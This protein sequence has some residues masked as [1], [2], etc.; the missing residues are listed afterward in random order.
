M[1]RRKIFGDWIELATLLSFIGE[2]MSRY[3]HHLYS[4]SSG[5]VGKCELE[6]NDVCKEEL[7]RKG[8][9]HFAPVLCT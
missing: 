3:V 1:V 9:V 7:S 2:A 8:G 5:T 6:A 4:T